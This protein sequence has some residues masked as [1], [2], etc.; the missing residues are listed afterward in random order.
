[1]VKVDSFWI[2]GNKAMNTSLKTDT[3]DPFLTQSKAKPQYKLVSD[4]P[5]SLIDKVLF[6]SYLC[7]TNYCYFFIVSLLVAIFLMVNNYNT[8]TIHYSN[9]PTQL[10]FKVDELGTKSKYQLEEEICSQIKEAN[11]LECLQQKEVLDEEQ[12]L[13]AGCCWL[14]SNTAS[15]KCFYP[16]NH[17][18]YTITNLSTTKV[19]LSASIRLTPE[20]NST[21]PTDVSNLKV[22]F[23]YRTTDV[24]QVKVTKK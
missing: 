21:F 9:K 11:R 16:D 8:C 7:I 24:L 2:R 22:D 10:A 14:L 19:G 20:F 15:P 5:T 13:S 4:H 23:N 3:M 6:K 1:M 12:C 18:T 17:T